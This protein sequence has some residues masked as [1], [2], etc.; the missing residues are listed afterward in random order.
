MSYGSGI[1]SESKMRKL[2]HR[3]RS[4]SVWDAICE[5]YKS[6]L[7]G[8][9]RGISEAMQR[10]WCVRGTQVWTK[11]S[12]KIQVVNLGMKRRVEKGHKRE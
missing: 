8:I 3:L 6:A 2:A 11:V 1:E 9:M 7:A 12:G 10:A 5:Q 4:D